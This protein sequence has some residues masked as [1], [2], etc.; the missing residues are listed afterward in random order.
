MSFTWPSKSLSSSEGRAALRQVILEQIA[1]AKSGHPGGSLSLVE[2]VSTLFETAF[3]HD[4]KNPDRPDRDRLVLSKGHGVPALY[5]VLSFA[6]YFAPSELKNLR[7]LGHFLQGHP[8]RNHYPLMEASTGSLGQGVS[9]ALGLALGSRLKF[10]AGTVKRLPR[11][12][13]VVGDGEMQEG[14]VWE[15]LM[16][17]PKFQTGNLIFVLDYNKGQIDG[18]VAEVMNLEPLADKVRAFNWQV[19]EVDGHD[20][21]AL[22]KLWASIQIQPEAKPHFVIAHTVK[23]KGISFMEHPTKWHGAAPSS[24]QLEQAIGEL[25]KGQASPYGR[26]L[27]A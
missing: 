6:G 3:E 25:F 2:I 19:H 12:Y 13:C 10:K 15:A 16:A 17:A 4:A 27:G 18:P 11:V 14:Q 23:G 22:N 8:D 5:S 26:L 21:G 1:A 24:E 20:A 9:V 7:R